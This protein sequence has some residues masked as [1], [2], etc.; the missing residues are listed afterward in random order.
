MSQ[1]QKIKLV[2]KKVRFSSLEE[3]VRLQLI[4]YCFTKDIHLTPGDLSLLTHIAVHGYDRKKT[5][6]D[7][8]E[9]RVFLHKQSVRNTRNK[10]LKT[11]FLLEPQK[12]EYVINPTLELETSG[13][14]MVNFKAVNL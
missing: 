13:H 7:L 5:P 8:V 1:N 6:A 2:E 3:I 9:Q 10:L 14:V 11:E 4:L 12:W